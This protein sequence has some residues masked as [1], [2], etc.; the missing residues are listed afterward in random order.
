MCVFYQLRWLERKQSSNYPKST[1]TKS[2]RLPAC[3]SYKNSVT[4]QLYF[5]LAAQ[6]HSRWPSNRASLQ[7]GTYGP[8]DPTF[9]QCAAAPRT[10]ATVWAHAA[11][12]TV[13][14][15]DGRWE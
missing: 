2:P 10:A 15:R 11:R 7:M 1:D 12:Q 9:G 5:A 3:R 4:N 14:R 6:L 13:T 8:S